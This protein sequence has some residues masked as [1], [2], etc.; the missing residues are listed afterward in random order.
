MS[1]DVFSIFVD[2][3]ASFAGAVIYGVICFIAGAAFEDWRRNT[4]EHEKQ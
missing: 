1:M 3:V 2:V 4:N